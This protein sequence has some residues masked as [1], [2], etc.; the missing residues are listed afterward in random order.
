MEPSALPSLVPYMNPQ[1]VEDQAE[2]SS[3]AVFV[4]LVMLICSMFLE[5]LARRRA[6]ECREADLALDGLGSGVLFRKVE[7]VSIA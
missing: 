5:T 3:E 7:L 1:P 6:L 4:L 2:N